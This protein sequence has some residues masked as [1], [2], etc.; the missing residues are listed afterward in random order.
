MHLAHGFLEQTLDLHCGEDGLCDIH[1]LAELAYYFIATHR[2]VKQVD[3]FSLIGRPFTPSDGSLDLAIGNYA[4]GV[5]IYLG[6]TS[7][8][9]V[10][11]MHHPPF[12]FSIYP[13]PVKEELTITLEKEF[14]DVQVVMYNATGQL[15]SINTYQY[16]AQIN[17][18][19]TGESGIYFVELTLDGQTSRSKISKNE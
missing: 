15:V 10:H 16:T 9:G 14:K 17:T 18:S 8:T 7:A 6:D 2:L 3:N 13:N 19:L 5:A 11:E 4:G 12:D 1:G